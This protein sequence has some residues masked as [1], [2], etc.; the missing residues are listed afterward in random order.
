MPREIIHSPDAGQFYV[1]V[2]W[3]AERDVQVGVEGDDDLHLA[4]L[5]WGNDEALVHLGEKVRLLAQR[6][7]GDPDVTDA[8]LGHDLLNFIQAVSPTFRGVWSTL[9]RRACNDLIRV[10]RRARDSAFGRDE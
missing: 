5:L 6:V 7:N 2:G 8:Q 3:G 4:W 10:L 1:K 9:D